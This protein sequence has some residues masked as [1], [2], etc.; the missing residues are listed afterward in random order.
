MESHDVGPF[1]DRRTEREKMLA[2]DPY[3]SRDPALLARYELARKLLRELSAQT[4]DVP[5]RRTAL[6]TEL[7]GGV[8]RDVWIELPFYCDYGE[9]IFLG[10]G[11]FINYNCVLLDDNRIEIG[12]HVLIGPA[13]QIYTAT[14]PLRAAER[15]V[16]EGAGQR[17]SYVTQTAPVRIGDQAWIG[18]G[19]ILL[20]GVEIGAGT[21]IGAGSV[22]TR[23]VPAHVFAAGNPCRVIRHLST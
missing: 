7:L 17:A 11:V 2:G 9:N 18:G 13:V 19:A 14:H 3:D 10:E 15:I 20:P 16:G 1:I 5:G 21:T 6:L 8:G 22:V 23:S 4:V 12:D